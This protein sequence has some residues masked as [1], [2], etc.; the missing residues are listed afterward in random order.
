M[1]YLIASRE[2]ATQM[3]TLDVRDPLIR[4]A[5]DLAAR[6]WLDNLHTGA[7]AL[8]W[9]MFGTGTQAVADQFWPGPVELRIDT[10]PVTASHDLDSTVTVLIHAI[11]DRFALA[12]GDPLD[13][14]AWAY[15]AAAAELHAAVD[16]LQRP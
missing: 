5:L 10:G 12:A 4:A 8:R 3:P 1:D 9:D 11:A 2:L 15:S 6:P 13:P 14:D 16:E 7:A